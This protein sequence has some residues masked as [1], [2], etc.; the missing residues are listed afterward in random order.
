MSWKTAL[1]ALTLREKRRSEQE[2]QKKE[3]ETFHVDSQMIK[4]GTGLFQP[5]QK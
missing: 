3:P 1:P 2:K 4:G 5:G